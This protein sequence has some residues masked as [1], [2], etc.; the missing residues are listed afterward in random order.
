MLY[1]KFGK[2]DK[3]LSALGFGTNRFAVSD[4]QDEEGFCRAAELIYEGCVNG[5]NYIDC[6]HTYSMGKG[7]EIVKRALNKIRAGG[8][9]CYTSLKTM[10]MED[11]TESQVRARLEDSLRRL[12][13]EKATFGFAWRVDSFKEFEKMIEP[14]GLYAGLKRAQNEGIIEHIVFSSH[15]SPNETVEIIKSGYFEGCMISCNILN[16]QSYERVFEAAKEY[17]VGIFTMNSLGGGTIVRMKELMTQGEESIAAQ[18]L[19]ALYSKREVTTCLSTMQTAK[20]L[21]ENL[22]AFKKEEADEIKCDF[23]ENAGSYCTKCRYCAGCPVDLPI[24]EMM[25]AYNNLTFTD[26]LKGYGGKEEDGKR[27]LFNPRFCDYKAIPKQSENPCI[28]CGRCETKCTQ[29]LPI[30]ERIDEFYKI[31]IEGSYTHEQRKMRLEKKLK[32]SGHKKACLFPAGKYTKYVLEAYVE[33][34]GVPKREIC[35]SDNNSDLW[36]ETVKVSEEYAVP[37][38]SP[39]SIKSE[40]FDVILIT[41]YNYGDEIYNDFMSNSERFSGIKIDKLHEKGDIPWF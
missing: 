41:N 29:K 28:K 3:M 15:A 4:L 26:L 33:Y 32:R 34:F 16:M 37:I 20:E 21:Y 19:K 30:I 40:E 1:R 17:Q 31:A 7:E 24:S 12:D 36:G 2:T 23:W 22:S 9:E 39:D 8:L 27:L 25:Y 35:I 38:V 5:I 18:A 6:A 14:G 11:K 13:I 10:Y